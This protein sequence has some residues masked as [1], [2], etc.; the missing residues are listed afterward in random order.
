MRLSEIAKEIHRIYRYIVRLREVIVRGIV[1]EIITRD[2]QSKRD[3]QRK[4]RDS[5]SKRDSRRK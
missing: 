1:R 4:N 5:N 3:S 2:S